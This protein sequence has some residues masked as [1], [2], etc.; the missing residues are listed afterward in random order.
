MGFARG[1]V[2]LA[3]ACAL[4]AGVA[5]AQVLE[6]HG[7]EGCPSASEVIAE[8]EALTGR[9]WAD[10]DPSVMVDA[11]VTRDDGQW[12]LRLRAG[13]AERGLVGEDCAALGEAA[14]LLVAWMIDPAA[15]PSVGAA[16]GPQ[17]A[18]RLASP[19]AAGRALSA[20]VAAPP[21][22]AAPSSPSSSLGLGGGL[23]LDVGT[24][25]SFTA[26]FALELVLRLDRLDLRARGGWLASQQ[27]ELRNVGAPA[28]AGADVGWAG[29]LALVCGRPFERVG[30]ALCAG[31]EAG[32]LTAR[33][34]GVSD[35]GQGTA[36]MLALAAGVALPIQ[37]APEL[38]LELALD[39]L[40]TL[41]GPSFVVE[42]FGT[43]YALPR[44]AG[45][46]SLGAHIDVR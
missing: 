17:L 35:P 16:P 5:H 32:A 24:L 23:V 1:T 43:A 10:S 39:L 20:P 44:L 6:F 2:W 28:G 34:L 30:P 12:T 9:R 4:Q 13:G 45:R 27:A 31:L 22:A 8:V 11:E 26:G 41:V 29:G 21:A 42:P 19:V 7:P 46:L 40:V 25:P 37:L 33:A 3:L 38:D 14:A 18:R 15:G 36:P